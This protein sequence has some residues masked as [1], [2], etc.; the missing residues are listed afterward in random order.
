MTGDGR[1]RSV[2]DD[3]AADAST[4]VAGGTHK[5]LGGLLIPSR[6]PGVATHHIDRAKDVRVGSLRGNP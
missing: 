1:S 2:R 5:A 6:R 4:Y 3:H